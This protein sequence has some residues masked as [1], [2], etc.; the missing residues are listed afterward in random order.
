[1]SL[2][3]QDGQRALAAQRKFAKVII[4]FL[5]IPLLLLVLTFSVEP[6]TNYLW[7]KQD[8]G[9]PQVF[10]TEYWARGIL[11]SIGFG[12]S[13][14]LLYLSMSKAIKLSLIFLKTPETV[15]EVLLSKVL[16][17]LQE[18]GPIIAKL[19][20]V[21]LG[22]MFGSG[23]SGEWN[24]L[25]LSQH[26]VSFGKADPIFGLD[27]SFFVFTLPWY[28]VIAN[29]LVG[30]FVL[31]TLITLGI[32]LGVQSLATI[33][34]IQLNR[35]AIRTHLGLLIGLAL[36]VYGF[37][38]WLRRYEYGFQDSGQ[39]VG[40]GYASVHQLSIQGLLSILI[41]ILAVMAIATAW[42]EALV[43]WSVRWGVFCAVIYVLGLGVYP[44]L[45]QKL[46]VEPNKL[47]VESPY[48]K[49]AIDMTR[50]A[51]G[52]DAIKI[53]ETNVTDA[54][55]SDDLKVSQGTLENMRLWDPSVLRQSVEAL[56]G[57]KSYY[58]FHDVDI[59]RYKIAGK[60]QMVMLSPRDIDVNGLSPDAQNWVN[61][62]LQYTHGYG[63]AMTPVN[64]ATPS[65]RPEFIIRDV[66]PVTPPD[67]PLKQPRVYFSDFMTA[68][69]R[70][71]SYALVTSKVAEFDYPS[72][73]NDKT[74][75]WDGARG[76][77][78]GSFV[79][80]LMYSLSLKDFNL[81]ISPN[82]TSDT[83]LLYHRNVMDRAQLIYPFL[84]FDADP[85]I[86]L[87][88]GKLI[89]LLDGYTSSDHIPYSAK[90]P[91]GDS[92]I[93]YI[94]NPVKVTVD[95]Y[96]G[97]VNAY[98]IDDKEPILKAYEQI[99]PGLMKPASQMPP[100]LDTHFRYPE[101]M[102]TAQSYELTQY[103]VTDPV[104][105]LN[106]EDAWDLPTERGISGGEESMRPY[107]VQ[108][109]LPGDPTDEFMLILPFTP[110]QKGNMSGWL[111]ADCD[112]GSYGEMRLYIYPKGSVLPGPKQMEANFNQSPAIAN[113]NT[114]LK[115]AQSQLIVGNLLVMPIGSSVMY[116][117]PM[118][119]ES[120][121]PGITPIPELKKVILALKDKIV[122]G[123]NYQDALK[124]LVGDLGV[125]PAGVPQLTPVPAVTGKVP[126]KPAVPSVSTAHTVPLASVKEALDLANRADAALR[127]GD[128]AKYGELQKQLKAKLETI[129]GK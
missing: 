40:A 24:T 107:Y 14:I 94:R 117:E 7:F 28:L 74:F 30:L 86:V 75:R 32:Y 15:S 112:P 18:R 66:P 87:L 68:G 27:L 59:D 33:A 119:L 57:L 91:W 98:V 120:V 55:T 109:R 121:S 84:K 72:E 124:E 4:A 21:A 116:V 108:M 129:V 17:V 52:I 22:F 81:L 88:N 90:F 103:H 122:V 62:R 9:Y 56:Q 99:Y 2:N 79:N 101:D 43:K 71:D 89:W 61:M 83:R 31:A 113:L 41:V 51:Y 73:A 19:A 11:F 97:D 34:K 58:Q 96:T 126:T 106:N 80:R 16:T 64:T 12:V 76:V 35:P 13:T 39:F 3:Q 48:A 5:L 85:Y 6:F 111:A 110:R 95:A 127:S 123:D 10:T 100:G 29:F 67:L 53:Q 82:I 1:M 115:N 60:Q 104:A 105:F 63:I 54:P 102:F 23:L 69:V 92:S 128:F 93:N 26:V 46:Y 118:F 37:A 8:A 70:M 114:L 42:F 49:R 50:Y 25:L 78:V 20:A 65:G 77:Q 47:V 44:A 45:L 36:G 125:A 38:L